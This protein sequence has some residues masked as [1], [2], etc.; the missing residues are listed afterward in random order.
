MKTRIEKDGTVVNGDGTLRAKYANADRPMAAMIVEVRTDFG[1]RFF[2]FASYEDGLVVGNA[3]NATVDLQ[4]MLTRVEWEDE[5]GGFC[6]FDDLAS[7]VATALAR[8][9]REKAEA[10]R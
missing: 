9:A 1:M 3:R 5:M 10:S 7:I 8:E 2:V 6:S 4:R